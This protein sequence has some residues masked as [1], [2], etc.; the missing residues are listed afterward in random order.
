MTVPVPGILDHLAQVARRAI[1]SPA[2]K[3]RLGAPLATLLARLAAGFP[4]DVVTRSEV[5]GSFARDTCLPAAMDPQADID[6]LV[7]F[8]DSHHLPAFYLEQLQQFAARHYPMGAVERRNGELHLKLAPAY[9]KL[10]PAHES[11]TGVDVPAPGMGWRRIDPFVAGSQ[12]RE[13]DRQLDGLLLS[14]V[15]LAKYWNARNDYPFASWDLEQR[16]VT[17][18]YT[19]VDHNLQACFFELLRS[20]QPD[21]GRGAARAATVRDQQRELEAIEKLI[22][23]RHLEA[24][25][26]R[27]EGM[28]PIPPALRFA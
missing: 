21:A 23:G 25:L 5:V 17:H 19:F 16:V 20:L 13:K 9:I 3:A 24:A 27:V 14:L 15:R 28:L 10:V 1:L 6:V 11:L 8:R 7:I 2:D 18:R 4:H 12:L 22:Q 26:E